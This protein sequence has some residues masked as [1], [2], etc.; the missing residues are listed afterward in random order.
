M[1]VDIIIP[2]YNPGPYIHEA[3]KSA[4]KQNYRH[5]KVIV[6]DDHSDEDLSFLREDYPGIIFHRNEK[7][8]G[9]SETRNLAI[10]MGEGELISLLDADDIMSPNKLELS[11]Q[12]FKCTNAGMTCGNY[13]IFVNRNKFMNPFYK[14]PIKVNWESLLKVNLV[15]SGS[16]TIRRDVIEK[17]GGFDSRYKICEDYDLWV[18]IAELFPIEYIHDVLYFYS[19][20]PGNQS[21]TQRQDIQKDHINNIATIIAESKQRVESSDR[22]NQ[23]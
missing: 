21:L 6:I 19:V 23:K 17:V 11:V 13:R 1:L 9:V 7:N 8:L 20:C 22:S 10:K 12:R 16:T 2:A 14:S 5:K 15:A 18:R 4:F 3:I